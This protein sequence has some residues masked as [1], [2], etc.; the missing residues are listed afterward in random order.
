MGD[1]MRCL[2]NGLRQARASTD[3]TISYRNTGHRVGRA[4]GDGGPG[5]CAWD[6][7]PWESRS[8]SSSRWYQRMRS[9]V[10][11]HW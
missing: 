2:S 1:T 9:L 10:P 3:T 5:D 11:L 8:G 7:W 6:H 4:E